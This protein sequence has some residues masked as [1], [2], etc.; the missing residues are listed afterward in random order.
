MGVKIIQ[1]QLIE[2]RLFD[3]FMKD[4][5]SVRQDS[6]PLEIEGFRHVPVNIDLLAILAVS[7]NIRMS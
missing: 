6:P 7:G 1:G 5:E 2:Q 3:R 4:E